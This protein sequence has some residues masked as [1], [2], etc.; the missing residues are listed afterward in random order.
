[1]DTFG[2]RDCVISAWKQPFWKLNPTSGLSLGMNRA[3][4]AG[5]PHM[6]FTQTL[7]MQFLVGNFPGISGCRS[8]K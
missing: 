2:E 3:S 6:V 5:S 1:M 8:L 4:A 7:Q